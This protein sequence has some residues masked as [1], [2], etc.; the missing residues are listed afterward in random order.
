MSPPS[1]HRQRL[2]NVVLD[3]LAAKEHASE[4]EARPSRSSIPKMSAVDER[5][6]GPAGLYDSA[7]KLGTAKAN[8]PISKMLTMGFI[9]G[10]HIAFGA[11]LMVSV[12]GS[13]PAIKAA[14]PGLQRALAGLFGLP[15]GLLMTVAAGG[16]LCTGNFAL[17]T[18]ALLEAKT[19]ISK[20]L[21]N[22]VTVTTGNLLG[23]L[24]LAK[25]ATMAATGVG[26]SAVAIATAKCSAPFTATLCKGILCNWL[27]SMGV[28]MAT[29][30]SDIA[31]KALIMLFPIV[32]FVALGLEHCVANMFLIPFGMLQGAELSIADFVFKN[33]IPCAIGNLIGGAI[34]VGYLYKL[35]YG[36]G[37]SSPQKQ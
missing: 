22:W 12:G 26:A 11:F 14:D 33:L 36:S 37:T 17:C 29:S 8:L 5:R 1:L 28:W 23:S 25:L 3:K 10:A 6:P 30:T 4:A 18:T 27:V 19:T 15:M 32:G 21:K 16:E 34:F 2:L 9:S 35:S 13:V 20:V 7:V 24:F 31:A